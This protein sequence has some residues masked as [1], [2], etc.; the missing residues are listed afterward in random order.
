MF[1]ARFFFMSNWWL[2]IV[3]HRFI[4]GNNNHNIW[5]LNALQIMSS[6]QKIFI[7]IKMFCAKNF[8]HIPHANPILNGYSFF[9]STILCVCVFF[10]ILKAFDSHPDIHSTCTHHCFCIWIVCNKCFYP[11]LNHFQVVIEHLLNRSI[12]I[13][14]PNAVR[15]SSTPHSPY[16][17]YV[18]FSWSVFV[19]CRF[20]KFEFES[21]W[22]II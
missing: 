6:I 5:L 2:Y 1:I 17:L 15:L 18:Y 7:L 22:N 9:N 16:R 21:K 12:K 13:N 20:E 4:R 10:E 14:E 11:P 8:F 19:L 3:Q